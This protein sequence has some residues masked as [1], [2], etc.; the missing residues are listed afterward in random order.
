MKCVCIH[1]PRFGP[2]HIARLGAAHET[3][4]K[5]GTEVIGLETA[6]RDATY[7]WRVVAGSGPFR[8]EQV[9][10]DRVFETLHP[11]EVHLGIIGALDRLQ[12]DAVVINSYS[13]PDSRACL[14][15]CRRNRRVAVVAT[16]SKADDAP[17]VWWRERMKSQII[18]SF[19]AAIVAGTPHRAYLEQLGF[20]PDFIFLGCDVVDN[21]FFH[22][23][24]EQAR[25]QPEQHSHLPGLADPTPFF[26]SSNRLIKVKNVDTL[27]EAYGMYRQG[28]PDPW[29]LVLIGEGAERAKLEDIISQR[30]IEGVTI[31]G[32]RQLEDLP[33]YYG[34]AG[35]YIHPTLKDTWG[36]VVNEAM[37]SGLPVLV[38]DRAGCVDDLVR[39]GDNGY[40]F[41]PIQPSQLAHLMQEIAS[42]EDRRREMA[43]RSL[44]II[45][46]WSLERYA[47]AVQAAAR[48]GQVR[49][50]RPLGLRARAVMWM[51]RST[52]RSV[53]SFH[54]V[55]A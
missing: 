28:R 33:A 25:E 50:G 53:N 54:S 21:E 30:R 31:T 1:W 44:E 29:R 6:G 5:N 16:D 51:I 2:Y 43:F 49:A 3:L 45:S 26:L 18:R 22:R 9:F 15:W 14:W 23:M 10:P 34:R 11:D 47:D 46:D 7:D 36:L 41:D 19:D 17:R 4:Q 39:D 12:P 32:F 42:S 13:F 40:R 38:S 20:P 48:A 55:E 35:A 52:S 8:R 27:L 37:A 24:A